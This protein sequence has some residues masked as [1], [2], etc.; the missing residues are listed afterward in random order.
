MPWG[1]EDDVDRLVRQALKPVR[2]KHKAEVAR[3]KAKIEKLE[4]RLKQMLDNCDQ[5]R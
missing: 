4:T 1:N 3:L 5:L 2:A